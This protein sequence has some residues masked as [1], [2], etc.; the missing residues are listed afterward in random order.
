M[1]S[2]YRCTETFPYRFKLCSFRY[3]SFS[4]WINQRKTL[5]KQYCVQNSIG[6]VSPK[7]TR[8]LKRNGSEEPLLTNWIASTCRVLPM[9]INT[10]ILFIFFGFADLPLPLYVYNA[11]CLVFY[12]FGPAVWCV[13]YGRIWCLCQKIETMTGVFW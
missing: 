1:F 12:D 13:F 2:T 7:P 5:A 3:C 8:S 6:L 4:T 9:T 11:V 10:N